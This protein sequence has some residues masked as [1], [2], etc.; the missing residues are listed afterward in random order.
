MYKQALKEWSDSKSVIPQVQ[1]APKPDLD[2]SES[3]EEGPKTNLS[4]AIKEFADQVAIA[5]LTDF[6]YT[7]IA[8]E[9]LM[10][11]LAYLLA[12]VG[13]AVTTC[14]VI[15]QFMDPTIVYDDFLTFNAQAPFPNVTVCVSA[16]NDKEKLREK[17]I[18]PEKVMKL[19]KRT[20]QTL[21]DVIENFILELWRVDMKHTNFTPGPKAQAGVQIIDA[22]APGSVFNTLLETVPG[23]EAVLSECSFEG[24]EFDCCEVSKYLLVDGYTCFL[25]SV[26]VKFL[27]SKLVL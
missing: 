23:C 14:H 3:D 5:G 8:A 21:D 10:W 26:S 20:N 9:K 19:I 18:I 12:I 4:K 27:G 2:E 25:M 15:S 24:H 11:T 17:L 22:T 16:A 1:P 6:Y 13:V 7:K